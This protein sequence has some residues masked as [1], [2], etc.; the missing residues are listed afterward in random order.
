V[1]W[2]Q[3]AGAAARRSNGAVRHAG[4]RSD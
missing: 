4:H 3:G 2:C 1:K